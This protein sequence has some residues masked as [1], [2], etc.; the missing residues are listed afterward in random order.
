MR[1]TPLPRYPSSVRD[2]SIVIQDS[3][4]AVAVRDTIRRA[5]PATLERV[6][7]FDR[8]QGTGVPDGRCSLSVRLTFRDA[9]RTLTDAEVQ[10]AVE[11][12]VRALARDHAAVLRSK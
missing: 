2:L 5:A 3:L 7:E 10:Q 8:Y 12:I 4:P 1:A 11:D 6:R 9:D